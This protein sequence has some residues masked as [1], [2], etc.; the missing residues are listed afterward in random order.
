MSYPE[1]YGLLE[2]PCSF[3]NNLLGNSAHATCP[4]VFQDEPLGSSVRD[5]ETLSEWQ[6]AARYIAT[7][8]KP[9]QLKLYFVSDVE[10]LEVGLLAAQPLRSMPTLVNCSI[11]LSSV[12][13]AALQALA[14]E[15]ASLAKGCELPNSSKFRFLDLPTEI[16]LKILEHT[17]LVT[18]L[19]EVEWNP[20]ANFFLRYAYNYAENGRIKCSGHRHDGHDH[21]ACQFHGCLQIEHAG[22]GCFCHRH[23]TAFSSECHCWI[24]PTPLFLVCKLLREEAQA[25]FFSE[26]HFVF[27]PAV[28][29]THPASFSP[30]RLEALTFF[31]DV[32][33]PSMLIFLRSLEIVCPPFEDDHLRADEPANQ[34]WLQ[35]IG[36]S[37]CQLNLPM[38]NL[39]IVMSDPIL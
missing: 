9:H 7:N 31:E 16:R 6:C 8:S 29:C 20:K 36:N 18:P 2:C 26:N 25:V 21:Y 5:N 23:H 32:L 13:S 28:G 38:L 14:F 15:V 24:S 22:N 17:D 34:Q 4:C 3:H 35:V 39:S 10:N 37:M 1:H 30:D 27:A 11:R 12:H 33:P 19:R